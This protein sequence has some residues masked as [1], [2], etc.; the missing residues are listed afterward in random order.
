MGLRQAVRRGQGAAVP[1]V[2]L[3]FAMSRERSLLS[4]QAGTVITKSG[5]FGSSAMGLER[6]RK[7]TEQVNVQ[8]VSAP[9]SGTGRS[10]CWGWK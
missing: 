7:R 9:H 2:N 3:R 8:T 4:R 1:T 6:P 5:R 10:T